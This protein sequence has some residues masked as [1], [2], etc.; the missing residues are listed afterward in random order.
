MLIYIQILYDTTGRPESKENNMKINMK[1]VISVGIRS[2]YTV[3][4]RLTTTYK[5]RKVLS[6]RTLVISRFI[7]TN[8][9]VSY[10]WSCRSVKKVDGLKGQM[11]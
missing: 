3:H 10:A 1:K 6:L 2:N 11:K 8:S 9:L 4:Y 7:V 5:N